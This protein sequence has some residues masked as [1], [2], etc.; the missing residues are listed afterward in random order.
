MYVCVFC[1]CVCIIV[2]EVPNTL[3]RCGTSAEATQNFSGDYY[4]TQKPY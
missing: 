2:R 1:P 4:V 3:F